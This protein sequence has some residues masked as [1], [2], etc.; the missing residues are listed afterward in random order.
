MVGANLLETAHYL[1]IRPFGRV[2]SLLSYNRFQK[3]L[4]SRYL[5]VGHVF[6][7]MLAMRRHQESLQVR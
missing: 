4:H 1:V 6:F 5:M 7:R 3:L 2:L